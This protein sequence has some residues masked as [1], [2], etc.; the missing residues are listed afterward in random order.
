MTHTRSHWLA[1]QNRRPGRRFWPIPPV[2]WQSSRW[3]VY[4]RPPPP[5]PPRTEKQLT[6]PADRPVR[7][8]AHA[9]AFST[10][11]AA[12]YHRNVPG[13]PPPSSPSQTRAP[14]LPVNDIRCSADHHPAWRCVAGADVRRADGACMMGRARAARSAPHNT[15]STQTKPYSASIAETYR[16][17]RCKMILKEPHTRAA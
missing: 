2:R 13:S 12:G 6:A 5:P 9:V 17:W 16:K 8:P 3:F 7:A 11:V 1:P 14:A 10:A 15:A 4:P